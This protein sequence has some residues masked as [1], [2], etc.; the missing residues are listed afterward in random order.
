MRKLFLALT[1]CLVASPAN[2]W[3]V[4]PF[5]F[6]PSLADYVG[7]LQKQALKEH[8]RVTEIQD[9]TEAELDTLSKTLGA[10]QKRIEALEKKVTHITKILKLKQE[11]GK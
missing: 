9:K 10:T 7:T 11:Q 2:A 3:D 8:L 5:A 4:S 1:L 6:D